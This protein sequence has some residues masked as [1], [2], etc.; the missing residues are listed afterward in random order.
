MNVRNKRTPYFI[1]TNI[2]LRVFIKE[3][4]IMHTDCIAL[5]HAIEKN[6]IRAYTSS[7]VLMEIH[8]VMKS[9]YHVKKEVIA[10]ALQ[11]ILNI[12]NLDIIDDVDMSV[13]LSLY[14]AHMIKFTDC[15]ISA[16]K[17]LQN[18]GKIIS[19]DQD[20]DALH[21]QRVEPNSPT[22]PPHTAGRR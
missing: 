7:I 8:Y 21:V 9:V 11:S 20:F 14:N 13:A 18:K 15:L 3:N 12:S 19:Y 17:L 1:D 2:F 10:Q 4:E 22:L 6:K 5:I 16:S